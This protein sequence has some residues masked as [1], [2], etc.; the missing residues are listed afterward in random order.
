MSDTASIHSLPM[1]IARRPD[2]LVHLSARSGPPEFPYELRGTLSEVEFN[3]RAEELLKLVRRY[4]WSIWERVYVVV[5]SLLTFVLP[6][7]LSIVLGRVFVDRAKSHLEDSGFASDSLVVLDAQSQA[8]FRARGIALGTMFGLVILGWVPYLIFK[9]M[10][11]RRIAA[12][13]NG[14]SASDRSRGPLYSLKWTLSS[15][16]AWRRSAV[17]TIVLPFNAQPT[18]FHPQAYLPPYMSKAGGVSN[19]SQHAPPGMPT[20]AVAVAAPVGQ[21]R[22]VA[23]PFLYRE[24]R[25]DWKGRESKLLIAEFER[26]PDLLS[27]V[28]LIVA[29]YIPLEEQVVREAAKFAQPAESWEERTKDDFYVRDAFLDKLGRMGLRRPELDESEENLEEIQKRQE[30]EERLWREFCAE[31][32]GH[33]W[34]LYDVLIQ[35]RKCQE[36][37]DWFGVFGE[38]R[39]VEAFFAM[40]AGMERLRELEIRNFPQ[41]TPIQ[42]GMRRN[43]V[44]TFSRLQQLT[45]HDIDL[46]LLHCLDKVQLKGLTISKLRPDARQRP[47][48]LPELEDLF[49]VEDTFTEWTET[50]L[51]PLLSSPK[52]KNIV[53]S[54]SLLRQFLT[55]H[56]IDLVP[57][58]SLRHLTLSSFPRH[59]D[60]IPSQLQSFISSSNVLFFQATASQ[61]A[62]LFIASFP[63]RL[64]CFGWNVIPPYPDI[65]DLLR[66]VL[67]I[68]EQVPQSKSWLLRVCA[69]EEKRA[70]WQEE[71]DGF[72]SE[73]P[74]GG[75]ILILDGK[76]VQVWRSP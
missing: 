16:S 25:I 50:L 23:T 24:I 52:L 54:F 55:H 5:V 62:P 19:V 57:P 21:W 61:L 63:K 45:V 10:G 32:G 46:Q 28:Q 41:S 56:P 59:L 51:V 73:Q 35:R 14:Y 4:A 60:N 3:Q 6:T 31:D 17:L 22:M 47:L 26:R 7:V 58:A 67:L 38:V 42:E 75:P 37:G 36:D 33:D 72:V 49:I 29:R 48:H 12:L 70:E 27:L 1:Y 66:T 15:T 40:T 13:L 34:E 11:N 8:L 2:V 69:T 18:N 65:S 20:R 74:K 76:I 9:G 30:S 44:A 39:K 64:G 68:V 71:W 53:T 43:V